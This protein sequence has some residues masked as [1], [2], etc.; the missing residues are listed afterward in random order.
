VTSAASIAAQLAEVQRALI[1]PQVLYFPVRHH[2]PACAW[3]IRRWIR[4]HRPRAVLVEGPDDFQPLLP[5]LLHEKCVP[6]VAIY[7]HFRLGGKAERADDERHAAYYPL[8][9]YSPEWVALREGHAVG[10]DLRFIDLDYASQQHAEREATQQPGALRI[11]SLQAEHHFRRS[12][13]LRE[14][15]RRLGCRDHDELWDH[16]IEVRSWQ[17]SVEQLVAD[18]AAYCFFSRQDTP[19]EVLEADGTLAREAV[20]AAAIRQVVQSAPA[21]D[22]RPVLVVTGGFHSVVLPRLV[23]SAP[24]PAPRHEPTARH[25]CLT[26]YTF[27]QLDALSGYAAGMPQPG[28]YQAVWEALERDE[29]APLEAVALRMLVNLGHAARARDLSASVSV[30]DEIAAL[31]QARRLAQMREHPGP[32]REDVWD[33]LRGCLVKGELGADGEVVLAL[34]RKLFT[35]DATG[36]VPADAGVPPLVEDFRRV[37]QMRKLPVA[38]G[39]THA[40][41]LEIYKKETHRETSRFLHRLEFLGVTYGNRRAGPDFL[42]GFDLRRVIEHWDCQWMPQTESKLIECSAYGASVEEAASAR[43]REEATRLDDEAADG[44]SS[45]V[46]LLI[47][48]C[49]MGLLAAA[50]DLAQR[51]TEWVGRDASFASVARAFGQLMLLWQSREPLDA[52]RL[53]LLPTL[54]DT[55]YAR[56]CQILTSGAQFP[57]EEAQAVADGCMLINSRLA[58]EHDVAGL[59]PELFWQSLAGLLATTNATPPLLRGAV[60]GLLHSGGRLD[61]NAVMKAVQG[62]LSPAVG[63]GA[64]QVDFLAGLLKTARELAWREPRLQEAVES[65]FSQWDEAEFLHRLP[66]LRLAWSDLTPRETDQVASQVAERH[67]VE[68][69]TLTSISSFTEAEVLHALDVFARVE[70]ALQE[71]GL[72]SWLEPA[73]SPPTTTSA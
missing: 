52:S 58:A 22:S 40:L 55:A 64:R 9:A 48:A 41:S 20:M 5:H 53:A 23:S 45:G 35:G 30:A 25:A 1:A 28:Y 46:A 18:V 50:A 13:Y 29:A 62:A 38:F 14:V 42:R 73:N 47:R 8:A 67:G 59:D 11:E 32:S 44:A 63:D 71:D 43:L 4:E 27:A 17:R 68:K 65:L 39:G 19:Y 15:G 6:P 51:L 21:G 34:A 49:L 2:S 36:D 66:H 24:A 72:A 12:A 61:A 31:E 54:M 69:R 16:L 33:A 56:A 37:A 57:E 3:Q 60:A 10:A 70:K 7:T 26:R